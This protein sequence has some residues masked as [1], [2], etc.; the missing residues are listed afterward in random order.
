MTRQLRP[1]I[2][3]ARAVGRAAVLRFTEDTWDWGDYISNVWD[4]RLAETAGRT[5]VVTM[6]REPVAV[7]HVALVGRG[8]AW[9]EDIRVPDFR[10]HGIFGRAR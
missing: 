3:A 1:Y 4:E 9:I 7:A 6:Q 5:L 2:R 8:E 10:R